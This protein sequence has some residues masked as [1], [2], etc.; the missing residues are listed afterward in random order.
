MDISQTLRDLYFQEC[1]TEANVSSK[2]KQYLFFKD[3]FNFEKYFIY[4]SKVLYSKVIKYR[5]GNHRLPVETGQRD[6]TP[7]NERKYNICTTDD[8]GDEY[9]YLFTCEFLRVKENCI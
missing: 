5:T 7:L 6:D 4:I 1:N 8:I 2:G 9:N 3:N